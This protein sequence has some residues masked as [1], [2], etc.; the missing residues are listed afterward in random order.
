MSWIS[1][2]LVQEM[3]VKLSLGSIAVAVELLELPQV[4]YGIYKMNLQVHDQSVS[5]RA[6]VYKM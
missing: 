3:D 2:K 6:A 1:V 4:K 5:E